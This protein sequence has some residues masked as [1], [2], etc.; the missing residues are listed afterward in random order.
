MIDGYVIAYG[1]GLSVTLLAAMGSGDRARIQAAGL[2]FAAWMVTLCTLAATESYAQ[3][4]AFAWLDVVMIWAFCLVAR[5]HRADW[6]WLIGGLHVL[7]LFLHPM[8]AAGHIAQAWLYSSLLAG[9]GYACM[10][11]IGG[12]PIWQGIRK[13][14]EYAGNLAHSGRAGGWA[15]H[16]H[17]IDASEEEARNK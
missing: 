17:H 10:L 1:C 6:A 2:L 7:M 13:A 4:A 15:H 5:L 16:P 12:R 3:P 9:L 11:V 8:Y 14:L